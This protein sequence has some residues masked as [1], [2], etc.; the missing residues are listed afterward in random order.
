VQPFKE[1]LHSLRPN[2]T[3]ETIPYNYLAS[4]Y[5]L[6]LNPLFATVEKPQKCPNEPCSSYLISGGLTMVIPWI[7]QRDPQ[8]TMVKVKS[9][10][11]IR[12]D[13]SGLIKEELSFE[14]SDC[15][16]FGQEGVLIGIRLCLKMNSAE[17][18]M[19]KAGR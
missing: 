6:V 17:P 4:A 10:P 16:L 2:Y 1:Y 11:S 5:T 7:P 9:A 14:D 13:F 18:G 3:Y 12:A 19:M 8:Y 15:D